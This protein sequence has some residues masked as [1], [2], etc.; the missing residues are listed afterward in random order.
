MLNVSWRRG[1]V[2]VSGV[3]VSGVYASI[4]Q[5]GSG[6]GGG[7]FA[8]VW[9]PQKAIL[10]SEEISPSPCLHSFSNQHASQISFCLPLLSLGNLIKC[11]RCLPGVAAFVY[12]EVVKAEKELCI[13]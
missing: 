7:V 10:S 5:G 2:Y 13:L 8:S 12:P 6:G 11:A 9:E 4:F 3:Y 1:G